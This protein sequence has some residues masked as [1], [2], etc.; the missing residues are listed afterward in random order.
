MGTV[1][2]ELY[3]QLVAKFNA[4][5]TEHSTLVEQQLQQAI[6][7]QTLSS[8]QTINNSLTDNA[9]T[10]KHLQAAITTLND[11]I[12]KPSIKPILPLP[13]SQPLFSGKTNENVMLWFTVTEIN[14]RLS[15]IPPDSYVAYSLYLNRLL[16]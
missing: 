7:S 6:S 16:N 11:K 4:L 1:D 10:I 14:F 13:S 3:N 5:N 15:N 9:E 12:T 8:I 2:K